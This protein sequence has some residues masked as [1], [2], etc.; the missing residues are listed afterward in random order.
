MVRWD[1]LNNP[2]VIR[3]NPA[4]GGEAEFRNGKEFWNPAKM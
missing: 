1:W 2:G 3:A 4:K